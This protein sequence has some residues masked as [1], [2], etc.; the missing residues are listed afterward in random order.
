M[1]GRHLNL[2]ANRL[3]IGFF[4]LAG[5][6]SL[7]SQS[8][9]ARA[10]NCSGIHETYCECGTGPDLFVQLDHISP[11][12]PRVCDV[13]FVFLTCVDIDVITGGENCEDRAGC[14]IVNCGDVAG[15]C[16]VPI[17]SVAGDPCY[18]CRGHRCHCW[19]SWTIN[20]QN[21][22]LVNASWQGGHRGDVPWFVAE[23]PGQYMLKVRA[24]DWRPLYQEDFFPG[25]PYENPW[26]PTAQMWYEE[27]PCWCGIEERMDIEI[28][29]DVPEPTLGL[30]F[31]KDPIAL[32]DS[33]DDGD[34]QGDLD[35]DLPGGCCWPIEWSIVG[36][37]LGARVTSSGKIIPGDREGYITVRA[38]VVSTRPSNPPGALGKIIEKEV[39]LG[40]SGDCASGGCGEVGTAVLKPEGPEV[41][42]SLGRDYEAK[43][44]G[45]LRFHDWTP[46]SDLARPAKLVYN[47][48]HENVF[49]TR[50]T[51]SAITSIESPEASVTIETVNN[52]K[53]FVDFR[54]PGEAPSVNPFIRW[55]ISN[56]NESTNANDLTVKK[57][58][59]SQTRAIY[60]YHYDAPTNQWTLLTREGNGDVVRKETTKWT[61]LL[62]EYSVAGPDDV[63]V[64]HELET[65]EQLGVGRVPVSKVIDPGTPPAQANLVTSSTWYCDVQNGAR[66]GR[67]KSVTNPDGSWKWFEYDDCGRLSMTVEPFLDEAMP[68]NP[69]SDPFAGQITNYNYSENESTCASDPSADVDRHASTISDISLG[70]VVQKTHIQKIEI[71]TDSD[72]KAKRIEERC[73]Q[74]DAPLG[75]PTNMRTRTVYLV[76]SEDKIEQIENPD[77]RVDTY[78]YSS[79]AF[80]LNESDPG[81]PTESGTTHQKTIIDHGY[82]TGGTP[83]YLPGKSTRDVTIATSTGRTVFEETH[84]RTPENTWERIVW[85]AYFHDDRGRV[86]DT[87]RSDGTHTSDVWGDCCSLRTMT[88]E[89]GTQTVEEYDVL[90][91]VLKSTRVGIAADPNA[92]YEAQPDIVTTNDYDAM[93]RLLSTTVTAG[94]SGDELV[95]T[96]GQVYD[97]AGRVLSSTDNAGLVTTYAYGLTSSGG[98]KVTVTHPDGG[99][100]VSEYFRDGRIKSITGSSVVSRFYDY[101]PQGFG[102]STI[103]RIGSSNSERTEAVETD[104]LGRTAVERRPGPLANSFRFVHYFYNVKG[105]LWRK[106]NSSYVATVGGGGGG[107][108][109]PLSGLVY[110]M[111][112]LVFVHPATGE[113]V[114]AIITPTDGAD[115][116]YVY[117][118][119]GNNYRTGVNVNFPTADDQLQANSRDRIVDTQTSYVKVDNVWWQETT[120]SVFATDN[121][122]TATPTGNQRRQTTGLPL[123]G[124]VVSVNESYDIFNNKTTTT[125]AID[126]AARLTTETTI[127]PDSSSASTALTRNGQMLTAT[128]NAGSTQHF[129]YDA[130]G[131]QIKTCDLR[132]VDPLDPEAG[133]SETHYLA[134]GRVDW[135]K[136]AAGK[137]TTY[138]Y[139]ANGRLKSVTKTDGSNEKKTYYAYDLLGRTTRIWGDVPQPV[140]M[141]YN[142][143]GERN[144]L[145]TYRGGTGWNNEEW[146]GTGQNGGSTG[147]ADTTQW[148]Y[149]GPSGFLTRKQFA[150][151]K[152]TIYE[153]LSSG[154]LDRRTWARGSF[155]EY[156]YDNSTGELVTVDHWESNPDTV[157]TYDRLGRIKTVTDPNGTVHT[158]TYN[159]Q[160]QLEKETI[161]GLYDMVVTRNY[162][163]I[164]NGLSGR[165]A[166]FTI[167]DETDP[168]SHYATTWGYDSFGRMNSVTGPGLPPGGVTYSYEP[169]SSMINGWQFRDDQQLALA[170]VTMSF[171]P[172]R[173]LITAVENRWG[174]TAVSKYA[175]ANDDLARR[176]SVIRSGTAFV[177][178]IGDHQEHYGYNDRNELISA[179]TYVGTVLQ[180]PGSEFMDRKR[181]YAYDPIGNR[182]T[183]SVWGGEPVAENVTTYTTNNVNQYTSTSNPS[184]TLTYDFDGNLT[185]DGERSYAWDDENRLFWVAPKTPTTGDVAWEYE[186]DYLGRR[187]R[188][189]SY[190]WDPTLNGGYGGWPVNP[191]TFEDDQRYVYDDWNV[192]LELDDS[193]QV[194][195]KCTWGLDLSGSP[196]AAGG[197]GG[198]L[199]ISDANATPTNSTDDLNYIYLYDANGNVGQL[200]DW[201][202]SLGDPVPILAARYEYDPYGQDLLDAN[203]VSACGPYVAA[204]LFRFGTKY[205]ES[206]MSLE[207]FGRR[208]Y[209]LLTGRWVNR[210]PISESGDLNLYRYC[211]NSP[212]FLS[213][214]I[215][216]WSPAD[217]EGML[218]ISFAVADSSLRV[219]LACKLAILERLIV[220]NVLQD[221]PVPPHGGFWELDR[222]YNRPGDASDVSSK[223]TWD[224]RYAEYLRQSKQ[225]FDSSVA[226]GGIGGC[227]RSLAALGR[228]THSWQDF[229]AHSIRR[230]GRGGKENSDYPGWVAWS[231]IPSL[232][233]S[234]DHRSNFW[235]S[236]YPGEHPTL[237]EPLLTGS[238]EEYARAQATISFVTWELQ[239]EFFP[240]F[241]RNCKCWCLL[242][243]K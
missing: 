128:S 33:C 220:Y 203:D 74:P 63:I 4:V 76:G 87:Y 18:D 108:H 148:I 91:R 9:Q 52:F 158:F 27:G 24:S 147:T 89:D 118:E 149:H 124:G 223:Q 99:T 48:R 8:N 238:A 126:A 83:A 200:I 183:S 174:S 180:A 219:S 23:K 66:L 19:Y 96:S 88:I 177:G 134:N 129:K 104:M 6:L 144:K 3:V 98:R 35:C 151:F 159:A 190:L 227:A 216:L 59:A 82:L 32:D 127:S 210:D 211:H 194:L 28:P 205:S 97:L 130:L 75:D 226:N 36:D 153:Y 41:R 54:H 204:N 230:D 228:L 5:G 85:T 212:I 150:N 131:R 64:Y 156:E 39:R 201:Q 34:G 162:Q 101:Q 56:P 193:N 157:Y 178:T 1:S 229:Y 236:S 119:L 29:I 207:Y 86:R 143:Y 234:P 68:S 125:R 202:A 213:D 145:K 14:P 22:N 12:E 44:V 78:S 146:P 93:G 199:S 50:D 113:T 232:D 17:N 21:G 42:L 168:D 81:N 70:A 107:S 79:V 7:F 152:N 196:H 184:E 231:A 160:L 45:E 239:Q 136:D 106:K 189:Y 61:G 112:G 195:R 181:G 214:P 40:S 188:K 90:G 122:A 240:K 51:N 121:N 137:Q 161:D 105:Q 241:S 100:D 20:D 26:I 58:I 94:P 102:F 209:S 60:E 55:E 13:V 215:G 221:S 37:S 192:V 141:E 115:V 92:G 25:Y 208:F 49:V 142:I 233:G 176:T 167:G 114:S 109:G 71:G 69:G 175:Y 80:T 10:Q 38:E 243:Q 164:P 15:A 77:G 224:W 31:S 165:A 120:Q 111:D 117:D 47:R 43:S 73:T 170:S 182:K 110:D 154:A 123:P 139:D 242:F 163:T 222:H 155:T 46:S 2:V 72:E 171:E 185:S 173:D 16:I 166:G 53:Y 206:K 198:L 116:I 84:V 133:W 67:L 138:E 225:Q 172:Q 218:R 135:V 95:Q 103:T 65:Y 169:N 187:V 197:I 62:R 217:H 237:Q 191:T 140:E 57:I 179:S 30:T 186:Y 132:H 11:E 235:P